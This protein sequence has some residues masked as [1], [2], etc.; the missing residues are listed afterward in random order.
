MERMPAQ[1]TFS[2]GDGYR[3]IPALLM[4][5][6]MLGL[7]MTGGGA[8]TARGDGLEFRSA[9]P[10]D[11][12]RS[13]NQ[14]D[15]KVASEH[16]IRK[17]VEEQGYE[18][19]T[20]V[21]D[22][23]EELFT[24]LGERRY[25]FFL[26]FGY[27]YLDQRER[28]GMTPR[29][30]GVREGTG[31]MPLDELLLVA[32]ADKPL[33]ELRGGRLLFERG[34]GRLPFIWLEEELAKRAL[35]EP[36]AFFATIEEG[37]GP[38]HTVLPVFFGKAEACVVSA[39]GYRTMVEL[40]PQLGRQLT[41]VAASEPLLTTVMCVSGE[42]REIRSGLIEEVGSRLHERPD[43]SQILTL[44]RVEKLV[45]FRPELIASLERLI[46]AR[47]ERLGEKESSVPIDPAP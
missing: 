19:R 39:D 34:S 16:L 30:V 12:L 23:H 40:N 28:L 24:G 21:L 44:M 31:E 7:L 22:N 45:P 33:E 41:V 2:R 17:I 5:T 26:I 14:A 37:Q 3:G 38:S 4:V 6:A 35:P 43:G 36:K 20:D 1:P 32:R 11:A 8:R 18:Y 25:D 42:F 46:R 13:V 10:L 15:A 9:I 47:R 27:E 29:L